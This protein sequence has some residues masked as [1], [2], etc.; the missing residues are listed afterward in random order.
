MP[1]MKVS[2]TTTKSENKQIPVENKIETE[3]HVNLYKLLLNTRYN[4]ASIAD[5]MPYMIAS[6]DALM[7][8]A[9]EKP[10][11]L[12]DLRNCQCKYN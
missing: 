10:I 12:Q 1:L 2:S 7:K 6:N 5:C 8:M 4:L 9:R 3:D 11:T